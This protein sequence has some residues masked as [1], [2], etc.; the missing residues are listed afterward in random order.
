MYNI[1]CQ[2]THYEH[3]YSMHPLTLSLSVYTAIIDNIQTKA[4]T[5][6]T[7]QHKMSH[8]AYLIWHTN[9]EQFESVFVPMLN[10]SAQV[11]VRL[12]TD[13]LCT[14]HPCLV[15]WLVNAVSQCGVCSS[16]CYQM[17]WLVA[18][19]QEMHTQLLFIDHQSEQPLCQ[20]GESCRDSH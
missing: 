4:L 3:N 14:S 13:S 1:M 17:R 7:Q 20:F 11:F 18:L 6:A 5:P 8:I 16:Y 2:Y 9:L 19:Q 12:P 15:Q 10:K